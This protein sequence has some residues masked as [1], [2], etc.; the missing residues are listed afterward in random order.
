MFAFMLLVETCDNRMT[1]TLLVFQ[2][3]QSMLLLKIAHLEYL[4]FE[5]YAYV[6]YRNA[7]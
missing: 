4:E 3:F 2:I 5:K 6:Y 1:S 7:I